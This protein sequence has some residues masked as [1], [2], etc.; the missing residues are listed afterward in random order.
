M[1]ADPYDDL[2]DL[3]LLDDIRICRP[4]GVFASA[5]GSG[6]RVCAVDLCGTFT[7]QVYDAESLRDA[8]ETARV[9][10][11]AVALETI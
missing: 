9:L 4:F 5:S 8:Y 7:L 1:S 6:W 11:Q 2:T 3:A 10:N